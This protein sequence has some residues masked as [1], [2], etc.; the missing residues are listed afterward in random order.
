MV[1]FITLTLLF[2]VAD[3]LF[4]LLQNCML[5]IA[6]FLS[7]GLDLRDFHLG[8]SVLITFSLWSN[9]QSPLPTGS[10]GLYPL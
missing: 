10:R 7:L 9:E 4:S 6:I 3:L 8:L 2:C 5:N 1:V